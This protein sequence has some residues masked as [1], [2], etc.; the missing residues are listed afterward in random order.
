[1]IFGDPLDLLVSAL[2]MLALGAACG[3]AYDIVRSLAA[4]L[5]AKGTLRDLL[6]VFL[7]AL[8]VVVAAIIHILALYYLNDGRLRLLLTFAFVDGF[9]LYRLALSVAVC[10][11]LSALL[12][13]FARTVRAIARP[14]AVLIRRA[15]L[16]IYHCGR[17]ATR[18]LRMVKHKKNN[19]RN[20]AKNNKREKIIKISPRKG[21]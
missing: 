1:M 16:P 18:R 20:K 11:L 6:T 4:L 7:D 13:L 8:A 3:L 10:K 17:A 21:I 5:G 14:I 15:I 9:V 2:W 19:K 12:G